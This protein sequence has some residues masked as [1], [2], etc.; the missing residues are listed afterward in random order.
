MKLV[1]IRNTGNYHG[2][3]AEIN[4]ILIKNV[5]RVVNVSMHSDEFKDAVAWIEIDVDA[6]YIKIEETAENVRRY[7]ESREWRLHE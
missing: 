5:A 7:N 1:S 3:M 2:W 6:S 4:E